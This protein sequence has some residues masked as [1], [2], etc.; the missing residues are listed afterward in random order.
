M[1]RRPGHRPY[2]RYESRRTPYQQRVYGPF[3]NP[4]RLPREEYNDGNFRGANNVRIEGEPMPANTPYGGE[5]DD[6]EGCPVIAAARTRPEE[7]GV[8]GRDERLPRRDGYEFHRRADYNDSPRIALRVPHHSSPR[9]AK[10]DSY[11]GQGSESLEGFFDQVEEY[12]AFYGW[13]GQEASQEHCVIIC[14]TCVICAPLMGGVE[15]VVTETIPTAGLNG[16][17]QG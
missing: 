17:L 5:T 1:V 3:A 6:E 4:S 12:T 14:Q 13:D 8:Q 16:H 10:M 11:S 9:L 15:G 7:T 2:V